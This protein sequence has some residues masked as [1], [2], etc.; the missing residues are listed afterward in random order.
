LRF[1]Y[2]WWCSFKTSGILCCINSYILTDTLENTA[3]S[4]L[5]ICV[6]PDKLRNSRPVTLHVTQAQR[7]GRGIALL[8]LNPGT[9]RGWVVRTMPLPMYHQEA[10]LASE[11]VWMGPENITLPG[12]EP[13][14]AQPTASCYTNWAVLTPTSYVPFTN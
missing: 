14:P 8:I 2:Q 6:A 7:G 1:S 4:T 13:W 11:W 12:F 5:K 3:S 10:G 9:K